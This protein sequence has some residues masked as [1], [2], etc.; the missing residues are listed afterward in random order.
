[1][2]FHRLCSLTAALVGAG[3]LAFAA[4]AQSLLTGESAAA[5]AEQPA[6]GAPRG[7]QQISQRSGLWQAVEAERRRSAEAADNSPH[8]LSESQRQELR[9]QVRRASLRE[10]GA[11]MS[12]AV[13]RP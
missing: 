11:L 12:P 1:M 10:D 13:S 4:E 8:R 3:T 6:G 9:D 5:P 2:S 7:A